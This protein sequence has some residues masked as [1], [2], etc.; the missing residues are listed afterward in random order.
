MSISNILTP[1]NYT[2]YD[3]SSV[4]GTLKIQGDDIN[5]T[6][7]TTQLYNAVVES[8]V[9]SPNSLAGYDNIGTFANVIVGS[10]LSL[11]G[12]ELIATGSGSGTVVGTPP[13]LNGGVAVYTDTSGL[14][15]GSSPDLAIT[16][17]TILGYSGGNLTNYI[18]GTNIE[19]SEG[20]IS[21]TG[22][23][24]GDV[25]W[26]GGSSVAGTPAIYNDTTGLIIAQP[27]VTATA[28]TL[29][30]YADNGKM[31]NI[32]AGSN[33]TISAGVI[34]AT[35]EPGTGVV[36]PES[37]TN[38]GLALFSGTSGQLI[39]DQ[40]TVFTPANNSL[41]GYGTSTAVENVT[42]GTGLSL[43]S[44]VLSST[45]SGSGDVS[46][47]SS[48][49]VNTP[50]VYGNVNGKE[51]TT[52]SV[53]V[54]NNTLIGYNGSGVMSN[55]SA[56]NGITINDG[57]ISSIIQ[58]TIPYSIQLYCGNP[59]LMST[60]PT[61][62]ILPITAQLY[63]VGGIVIDDEESSVTVPVSG[64]YQISIFLTLTMGTLVA[65]N[66]TIWM[67]FQINGS[68]LVNEQGILSNASLQ[69]SQSGLISGTFQFNNTSVLSAGQNLQW[70]ACVGSGTGTVN[71]NNAIVSL[72]KIA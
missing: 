46:G 6:I 45:A 28:D 19:I 52:T 5:Q 22:A 62:T 59:V 70:L 34:S 21:S 33:I 8:S 44:G 50:A 35:T 67:N 53:T 17:N 54:S 24:T 4:I 3:K 32:T 25:S 47:P 72:V 37:S 12:N 27:L 56:G 55:V 41:I 26:V 51:I 40:S 1:N 69:N 57:L 43:S 63:N 58:P 60:Y 66:R 2:I 68:K 29:L 30:G 61:F 64:L 23:G 7:T 15:I 49:V 39:Q 36:G 31:T 11:S 18:A 65:F 9:G 16:N 10:G 13:S 14:V 42:I 71:L 38:N 20:V 48:A